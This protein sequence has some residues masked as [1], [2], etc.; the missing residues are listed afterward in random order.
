MLSRLKS[1]HT[2]EM[3]GL[4]YFM[5]YCYTSLYDLRWKLDP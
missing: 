4:I 3:W 2:S 5:K 1:N